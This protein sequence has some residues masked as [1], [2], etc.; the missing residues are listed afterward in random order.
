MPLIHPTRRSL[1][2]GR[3]RIRDDLSPMVFGAWFS[4]TRALALDGDVLEVGVPE[5][6]HAHLDRGP[7]LRARAQGGERRRPGR[8]GALLRHRRRAGGA[9][10]ATAPVRPSRDCQA[11]HEA[12]SAPPR[13]AQAEPLRSKYTFGCRHR[14]LEPLRP[15]GRPGR[16][17]GA[18]PGLQPALHLRRHGSRQ[19]A[20][21]AGDRALRA[22][23][24]RPA[25]AS[26]YV[27]CEAFTNEFIAAIRDKRIDAFKRRYREEF[28]VLLIDDIQFL[29][30][31]ERTRRSSSTRS[32]RCTGGRQI[33]LSS[34]A[35][36]ARSRSRRP[37]ALALRVGPAR[38]RPAA[39]HRDADRDPAQARRSR[40]RAH[41]RPRAAARI[42]RRVQTTSASSRAR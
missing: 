33:V 2:R 35:R 7:L 4:T 31:K 42:A 38:R 29:A 40:S 9:P 3:D 1:D 17:G 25:C 24:T 15:C 6:V 23:C 13:R 34:T 22:R 36:R 16:R 8:L 30:G 14:Q 21:A 10:S 11:G 39:R 5:R 27:T 32:T 20:P 26:R 41:R 19:D 12:A 18:G 37:P 28:D